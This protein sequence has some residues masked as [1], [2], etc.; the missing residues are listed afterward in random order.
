[1]GLLPENLFT[2]IINEYK[3]GTTTHLAHF[4]LSIKHLFSTMRTGGVYGYHRIMYFNG[5]L[6]DDEYVP[7]LPTEI[8][9]SL[10]EACKQ[11]WS[12]IDPSIFGT[13]FERIIDVS[14]RAQLGA[15]YTSKDEISLVVEPVLMSPLR[16][17]WQELKNQIKD[18]VNN[19]QI[20]EGYL[21]LRAFSN[22][23]AETKVLD[24][25][26]GSGNFLYVSLLQLLDLQKEVIT[27]ATQHALPDLPLTV[28]PSQLYGI[29]LNPYAQELA[30]ITV[31]IGY[32]QWR[33]HNGFPD[34]EEPV[35][36]P[37][38]NIEKKD[39]ILDVTSKVVIEP[40]WPEV[41]II[42]GNPP[43]LG[44]RKIRPILGDK[45]LK[46]LKKL[47]SKRINGIPDIVCYWFVKAFDV[48]K[49]GKA[50]RVGLL[51][52]QAIRGG[53]NRRVLDRIAREG[54]I[55]MAWSDRN[56]VLDGANVHVSIIGFDNGSEPTSY[57]D[58]RKVTM[59]NS[60]LTSGVDLSIAGLLKENEGI[61]Y[62]GVVLRG[63]FDIPGKLAKQMIE[64]KNSSGSNNSDVIKR[65]VIGQ[66][67][68]EKPRDGWVIDFGV[69]MSEEDAKQYEL[70]Y[71][72]I[73]NIVYEER[74]K[75]KSKEAL[76]RWWI[77]WR[78]RREMREAINGIPRYI[79]TPRVGKHRVFSWV[80]SFVIP[81]N[82]LVIFARSDDYFFGVLHSHVHELWARRKGTQLRERESGFRYSVEYTFDTFP[83]P[84]P[85]G[86]EKKEDTKYKKTANLA[87]R[88]HTFRTGWLHPDGVGITFPESIAKKRTLTNLYNVLHIYRFEYKSKTKDANRWKKD[89]TSIISLDEIEEL[90]YIHDELDKSVIDLYGWA[91]DIGDEEILSELLKINLSRPESK[92]NPLSKE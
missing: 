38:Q 9:H 37:L 64:A 56:W 4:I 34:P 13:L 91:Q 70:P 18:M 21:A 29:E 72:H 35:L 33:L 25:A 42:I 74:K 5:S 81:D 57:L 44:S 84:W 32:L 8:L 58:G 36:R 69:E 15:H 2:H 23:I 71:K 26:C 45:Y 79:A 90:D 28:N 20:N 92:V 52:T 67:L 83:F 77:H 27:F 87:I 19:G 85:I 12:N 48:V 17:K 65:R 76:K 62:Q 55:F 59:I 1:M 22:E 75:T 60:D 31:W 16:T 88:L 43:F 24:P 78:S 40:I 47:Y 80:D 49:E 89:V 46:A 39:A 68:T 41:D 30:Q 63:S 51:A 10:G 50:K 61:G 54:K 53:T 7:D 11:D 73:R 14:K 3:Q 66:D 6:F 86:A 82:A